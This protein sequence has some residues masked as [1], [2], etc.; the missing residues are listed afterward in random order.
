MSN[1]HKFLGPKQCQETIRT[2][3]AMGCDRGIHIKT[4]RKTDYMELQAD[5]V[6]KLFQKVVEEK[7]K[8]VDLILMGK[9][10]IDS[11]SGCTG[12]MLAGYLNIGLATYAAELKLFE[13]GNGLLVE[14]ETDEGTETVKINNF[15]AVVTCD[16]R[17]VRNFCMFFISY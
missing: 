15:P 11:D 6:A 7:E 17:L 10:A 16:L 13:G 2:A 14:K 5:A 12:P 4:N 3:L 8:N 9:Q 1:S